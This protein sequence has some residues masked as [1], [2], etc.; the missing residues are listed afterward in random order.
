MSATVPK[1]ELIELIEAYAVA[2]ATA[3]TAL[4]TLAVGAVKEVIER[5]YAPYDEF[6]APVP[7]T[8]TPAKRTS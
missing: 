8:K 1:E 6:G 3:N 7:A 5:L 2:K 4:I